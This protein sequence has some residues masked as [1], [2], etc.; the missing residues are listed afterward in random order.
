MGRRGG[1]GQLGQRG[2]MA[3]QWMENRVRQQL[4][5]QAVEHLHVDKPGGTSGEPDR[6]HN[7][8]TRHRE[9]KP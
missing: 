3:R 4:A 1:D 6:P 8:G 2:L 5:E 9:I 7:A